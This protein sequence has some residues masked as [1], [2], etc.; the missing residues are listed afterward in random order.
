PQHRHRQRGLAAPG[1]PGQAEGFTL[2]QGQ[3]DPGHRRLVAAPVGDR[4]VLQLQ[5]RIHRC[6]RSLGLNTASNARPHNVKLSTTST[7]PRPG[8]SRYH[9]APPV[10]AP[11]SIADLSMAP[12]ETRLGSPSPR[13]DSVDSEMIALATDNVVLANTSGST[14]GSTCLVMMCR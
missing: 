7:I 11:V 1:F 8:G 5:N 3:A 14:L 4:H 13:N 12:Q 2:P 10:T 6:P 9:H